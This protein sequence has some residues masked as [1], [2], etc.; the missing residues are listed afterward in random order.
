MALRSR[1]LEHGAEVFVSCA[2]GAPAPEGGGEGHSI[3]SSLAPIDQKPWRQGTEPSE[4]QEDP[5]LSV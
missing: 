3:R 4:K 2:D 5:I 1:S